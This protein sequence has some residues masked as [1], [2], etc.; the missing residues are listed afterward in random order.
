[1]QGM[2]G[3]PDDLQKWKQK[4][5]VTCDQLK[6]SCTGCGAV[7]LYGRCETAPGLNIIYLLVRVYVKEDIKFQL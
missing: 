6:I 5:L 3:Q 7:Y 4:H 1:M 2:K